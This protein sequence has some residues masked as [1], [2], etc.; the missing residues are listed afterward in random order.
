MSKKILSK[1]ID[2]SYAN[3][4]IDWAK[5]KDNIDWAILRCGYGGDYSNQ[6][7]A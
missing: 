4:K 2:V 1:G 3:G 5:M 6:D 7:D